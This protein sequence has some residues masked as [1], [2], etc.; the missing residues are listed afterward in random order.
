MSEREEV[1]S[2]LIKLVKKLVSLA[3]QLTTCQVRALEPLAGDASTRQ[4]YRVRLSGKGSRVESAI[5]M[6]LT[7][8]AGPMGGG[9]RELT[10]DDTFFEIQSILTEHGV[11]VPAVYADGRKHDLLLVEDVGDLPLWSIAL[12]DSRAVDAGAAALPDAEDLREALFKKAI[13][14]IERLQSI[15]REDAELIYERVPDIDTYRREASECGQHLLA[16]R[17]MRSS[18][19]EVLEALQDAVSE[20][21]MAHPFVPCH[22]DYMAHNIY[23]L[24]D[25]ELCLIDFQD[26]SAVSPVRDIV[27][28]LNDRDID[29]CLGQSRQRRLLTYFKTEVI[30]KAGYSSTLFNDWYN[31]YLLH[32]DLR[33]SGRF[34][35]LSEQRGIERYAKWIPGTLRRLGRT[36]LRVERDFPGVADLLSILPQYAPEVGE[37]IEDPWALP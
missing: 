14:C 3:P 31:H 10:Q 25:G 18:E 30:D 22:F 8:A 37:G 27:S 7:Q 35:L 6:L 17:G 5:V 9:S 34:A 21:I 19:M 12:Q 16:P 1:S 4:F 23:V 36:L 2:E 20:S 26:A 15:P 13:L 11:R 33:V 28:L 24:P 32:W 29:S